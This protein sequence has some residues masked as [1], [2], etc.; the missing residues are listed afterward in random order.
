[1]KNEFWL[2]RWERKEIGFHDNEVNA[3]LMQFW[4]E[5]NVEQGNSIFVPLCGK[6]VDL[7]WLQEQGYA[8]LGIELSEIAVQAFFQE[9][10]Y[11]PK[12][13]ASEN[14]KHYEA[15]SIRILCGDFFDLSRDE[16]AKVSAVYD[17]AA[18]VALPPEMRERYVSHLLGILPP[19]TQILLITFDYPQSEMPGPPFALAAGEIEALYGKHAEIRLLGQVDV[20]AQNPRFQKRGL[21]RLQ[22]SVY[23]LTLKG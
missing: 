21:S 4:S 14:F 2:Q 12:I 22:E 1:M 9:N 6:S 16:L 23:L 18:M 13:S 7:K 8:V 3:Y 19:A 15:N 10:G 5:L 11:A 20:L 17:R